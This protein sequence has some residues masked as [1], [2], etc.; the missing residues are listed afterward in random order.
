VRER[1]A[2]LEQAYQR[3]QDEIGERKRGEHRL[4][5]AKRRAHERV[6]EARFAAQLE[7]RTRLA[8]EI[9]DTL[10]QGF[11]GVSLQLLA[12]MGRRSE[13]AEY[14]AALGQV[15][16]LAQKTLADARQAVWDMRPPALEAGDFTPTLRAVLERTLSD[17]SLGLDYVVRGVPRALPGEV[18]TVV[19]RVAQEAIANVLKHASA[20]T[21]RVTLA[22]EDHSVRLIVAD[23]GCG[24]NVDADLRTYAGHWG[25]LGMRERASQLRGKFRVRSAPGEGT[26]IV[27]QVPNRPVEVGTHETAA[28]P[29]FTS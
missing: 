1:T 19:F 12:A 11:T 18:E 4:T 13:P 29:S 22:Y 8:R 5:I 14:E 21:V 20:H 7:E 27:L 15:L 28:H 17:H 24:F 26:K 9:H 3:L 16:S 10:L 25:L 2:S 23:D 6:L